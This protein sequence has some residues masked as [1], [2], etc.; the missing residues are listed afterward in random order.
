MAFSLRINQK[1]KGRAQNPPPN[2]AAQFSSPLPKEDLY[3]FQPKAPSAPSS[4]FQ[5]QPLSTED[6]AAVAALAAEF[7][8]E[9]EGAALVQQ[10]RKRL[11]D[12]DPD[13]SQLYEGGKFK[14]SKLDSK[15][16]G[17][18]LMTDAPK[19]EPARPTPQYV[20]KL[21]KSATLR[22]AEREI[23]HEAKL[24]KELE[25][26]IGDKPV[27][28]YVTTGY[29]RRL[30]ERRKAAQLLAQRETE[31]PKTTTDFQRALY[32]RVLAAGEE[33]G[34][35]QPQSAQPESKDDPKTE[36]SADSTAT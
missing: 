6:Q 35:D 33:T 25:Q 7:E 4:L 28:S 19:T 10:K 27:V 5:T 13:E 12:E 11:A 30:E 21:L 20:D 36:P 8:G 23:I 34:V 16:A 29:K 18:I 3:S 9:P 24:V 17:L 15:K 32:T 22:G 14:M 2:V 1:G 26:E 31:P